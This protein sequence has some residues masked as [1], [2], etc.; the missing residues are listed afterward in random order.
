MSTSTAVALAAAV[1]VGAPLV[2]LGYLAAVERL[3]ALLPVAAGSRARPW[4]WLLPPLALIAIFLVYP[5][6]NTI[7]LS[8]EDATSSRWVG[9]ANYR[10]MLAGD[11]LRDALRNNVLWL[12]LL[13]GGCL[14]VGL[15]IAVLADRVRY[16][17]AAKSVVVLPT[18]VSFVAGAVIWKFM[19]DYQ[20]PGFPQTGTL[21]AVLTGVT[22][23][24][25]VPWLVDTHTNNAAL[26]AVGVWMT[27]G[28]ATVVISAALKQVPVEQ[29]EAAR[30]DGAGAWPVFRYVVLPHLRP[31]LVVVATLL[32][33][34][35]LKA[36]DA[37]YV[38]TNG[39]YGTDVI[40]N[41]LYRQLFVNSD[42]GRASAVAVLLAVLVL[43]VLLLNIR[44]LRR[45]E[46]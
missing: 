6:I 38:M 36:F 44:A 10:A 33:I 39:N 17:I 13:T 16:E 9:L 26:I 43:P 35:A 3:L 12:L 28:F 22:G 1:T 45:E 41:V 5:L 18:A 37:V 32:A 23:A 21:N 29:L 46:G 14:A 15:L 31:T 19:Y 4:A 42:Y 30:L 20:A 8:L 25:P 7:A 34:G 2:V 27:T 11:E 40:A 24:D